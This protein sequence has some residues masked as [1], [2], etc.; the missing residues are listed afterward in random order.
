[1]P[2]DVENRWN[3]TYDMLK[4]AFT[5]SEP[6]N[7]ITGDRSMKICQYKLVDHEW[8]IVERLQDCLKVQTYFFYY[9]YTYFTSHIHIIN[10]Q[11]RNTWILKQ[12]TLHHQ[13]YSRH[14]PNACW[15]N[16]SIKQQCVFACNS[17]CHQTWNWI[18]WQILLTY[19]QLRGI[20]DRYGF[21]IHHI[22]QHHL[23]FYLLVLHPKHKLRYF[24]KQGWKKTWITT[25]EEIVQEEFRKNYAAYT[26]QKKGKKPQSSKKVSLKSILN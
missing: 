5:Y 16:C 10:I 11:N 21:V 13:H 12:H 3:S 14:G 24:E 23:T 17:S 9:F 25:A 18:A 19:R 22:H 2:R 26:T 6:I 7:N 8:T 20:P 15:V 4:F 1:M